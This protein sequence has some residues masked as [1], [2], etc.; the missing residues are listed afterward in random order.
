[1]HNADGASSL[2]ST[3]IRPAINAGAAPTAT[4]VATTTAP[5]LKKLRLMSQKLESLA[6]TAAAASDASEIVK[7]ELDRYV[8]E[9]ATY[10]PHTDSIAFGPRRL[11]RL[12]P[13]RG[14]RAVTQCVIQV[15]VF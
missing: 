3:T 2:P 15:G 11:R 1:M 13:K 9:L 4:P 14:S 12:G 10:V 5:A 7:K 8:A 6:A